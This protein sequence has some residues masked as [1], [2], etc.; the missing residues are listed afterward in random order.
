MPFGER[1]FTQLVYCYDAEHAQGFF[2]ARFVP[3]D[4]HEADEFVTEAELV[5]AFDDNARAATPLPDAEEKLALAAF[6]A[7]QRNKG[8]TRSAVEAVATRGAQGTTVDVLA[9]A[10]RIVIERFRAG[11]SRQ[12]LPPKAASVD[13]A[14][15]LGISRAEFVDACKDTLTLLDKYLPRP[16]GL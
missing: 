12:R 4:F 13:G 8:F 16:R 6:R 14:D 15:P 3:L 9:P 2:R 11:V 5:L 7:Q 1:R 10:E